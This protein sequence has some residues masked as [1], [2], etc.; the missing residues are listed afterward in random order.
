MGF[1]IYFILLLIIPIWAQMKVKSAYKKYSKVQSSS[2]MTGAQVARK[3]L[4]DN[5]LYDVRIEEVRGQLTDHY[6][7]RSKVVR[8]SSEN[9]HGNSVAGAAVAAHEVGHAMQDAEDYAFLRFRHALVPIAG[10]GSNISFF[11]ILAGILM[12][13]SN[14]LLLGI[15]FMAAAVLFQVVT[16]PVEFN[17]SSRAMEQVVSVG[18]I[19]N[20]EERE[21]R[22]VLN[23]AALTYVAGA[24]VALLE[25]ARFI[26]M[27]IGMNNDD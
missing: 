18:V 14:L 12:G 16:L 7:P 13:A 6:D 24:L 5:G 26:L 27:Y 2:G 15:I 23:A 17:A 11:L 21:T 3:I 20:D 10:F 19:R 25:L 8:L 4:D 1:L 9:Y 22:K